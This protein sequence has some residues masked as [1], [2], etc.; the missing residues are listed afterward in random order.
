MKLKYYIF[1]PVFS[2]IVFLSQCTNNPEAEKANCVK[3]DSINPNGSSELSMLMRQMHDRAAE[4][5]LL[6]EQGRTLG[7]FPVEFK[8]LN[9]ATP[10]DSTT[11]KP[12][13]D[14]FAENYLSALQTVYQSE[15]GMVK[16]KYNE[17]VNACLSCHS[18]HCPGPVPKIRKLVINY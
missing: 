13:F 17:M 16:S 7:N 9:F 11:K 10:T 14:A 12:S 8:K 1:F 2:F 6:I 4:M 15:E 5:K 18:D 3:P